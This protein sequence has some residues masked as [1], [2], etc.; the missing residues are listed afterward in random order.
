MAQVAPDKIGFLQK[1][2]NQLNSEKIRNGIGMSVKGADGSAIAD[3]ILNNDAFKTAYADALKGNAMKVKTPLSFEGTDYNI[4][5][6]KD[7][8]KMLL[9]NMKAKPLTTL[10][11]AGNAAGNV[12]GL[13]DNS[14]VIGQLLGTVGGALLGSKIGVSPV[15]LAN[16]AMG[17]G[18][19]GSLFDKLKQKKDDE[20]KAQQMYAQ[21]AQ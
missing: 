3:D 2:Y 13:F 11:T 6:L 12:A 9:A 20:Q 19:V 7:T 21:Y 1:L 17:G 16:I 10:V 18:N 8:G 4:N 14:H 5:G 15:T